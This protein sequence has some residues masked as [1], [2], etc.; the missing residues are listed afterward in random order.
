[1]PVRY[2]SDSEDAT[3]RLAEAVVSLLHPGDVVTLSGQLGAGKTFFIRAAARALGVDQPVTSPSFT[4][5]QSYKGSL[6][7]HHLDLYRLP[8]FDIQAE[9]D[10]SSFFEPDAVTFIEWPEVAERYIAT[11]AIAIRISH[12][13]EHSRQFEIDCKTQ[14]MT[15]SLEAL[16]AGIGD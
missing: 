5:A 13:D 7:V 2:R 8:V 1:M 3:C 12:Q 9:A 16:I 14:E 11:P 10:F 6:P 15:G 4:M